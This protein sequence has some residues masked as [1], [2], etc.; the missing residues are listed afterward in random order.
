MPRYES[1]RLPIG[2][3]RSRTG[4]RGTTER[5]A[6]T[7]SSRTVRAGRPLS[8][9]SDGRGSG[10]SPGSGRSSGSIRSTR[11]SSSRSTRAASRRSS[12]SDRP[13]RRGLRTFLIVLGIIVV[14]F[15]GGYSTIK[16]AILSHLVGVAVARDG[17]VEE[18]IEG[19]AFFIR[20]ETVLRS[21]VTGT[22]TFTLA[23]GERARAE[24]EVANLSDSLERREAEE[25][26][27]QLQADLEAYD[28][29]HSVEE[30][31]LREELAQ[32]QSDSEAKAEAL[33][34]ACAGSDFAS[35]DTLTSELNDLGQRQVE[36]SS[37]LEVIRK[38]R[39]E[40]EDA[41]AAAQAA[42]AQ[43]IFPVL[44]P[45]PGFVSYRLD[46]LEELLTPDTIGQYGTKQ[47]LT[48]ERTDHAATD[49]SK[50]AAGDPIAKIIGDAGAY[51]SL[52]VTNSQ[53]ER[54]SAAREVTLRFPTFEGERE[55]A[56]TLYHV[57]GREKSGY[58]LVTY[59]TEKLLEGMIS[60]RQAAATVV[61]KTYTGT[62]VPKKAVVHRGG[63]DG[64]FVLDVTVCRFHPV[65]V[66]GGDDEEIVV[67]GLNP[68]TP[69]ISTPW[70]V[71]EGTVIG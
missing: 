5:R 67:E 3:A 60:V 55:T 23:E 10:K 37:R 68:G 45:A 8:D 7:G 35:I 40:I 30:A 1:G 39:A 56:A 61:A 24:E 48:M 51:V 57:G 64:V 21:P 12:A 49:Q 46:G 9:R 47:L 53:A 34:L 71:K 20:D 6:P 54:L 18:L 13:P 70:F 22:L 4:G 17:R 36:A 69:V 33:R 16:A 65:T 19:Q 62:V 14:L 44:A 50:V 43:V 66:L 38:D 28:A 26:L 59:A 2:G 25:R 42:M 41:L 52:I 27:S 58:C 15:L 32:I 11:G 63:E 29:E 31:A